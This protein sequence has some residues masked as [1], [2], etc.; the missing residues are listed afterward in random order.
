MSAE[1]PLDGAAALRLLEALGLAGAGPA[2][3]ARR[4][5]RLAEALQDA[6][7]AT[8][9]AAALRPALEHLGIVRDEDGDVDEGEPPLT[10][11]QEESLA[12]QPA[13]RLSLSPVGRVSAESPPRHSRGR[14]SAWARGGGADAAEGEANAPTAIYAKARAASAAMSQSEMGRQLQGALR[15]ATSDDARV[16]LNATMRQLTASVT[17]SFEVGGPL[18]DGF[19]QEDGGVKNQLRRHTAEWL[20]ERLFNESP[21]VKHKS[22]SVMTLLCERGPDTF[23][24]KLRLKE[25]LQAEIEHL[26]HFTIPGEFEPGMDRALQLDQR[27]AQL[28]RHA[29]SKLATLIQTGNS[30]HYGPHL[31]YIAGPPGTGLI[32]GM[33]TVGGSGPGRC[34]VFRSARQGNLV[35][36]KIPLAKILY[37]EDPKEARVPED[38]VTTEKFSSGT[39]VFTPPGQHS[40]ESLVTVAMEEVATGLVS[41]LN[42]LL[43]ETRATKQADQRGSLLGKSLL[44]R[45]RPSV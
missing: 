35:E 6:T 22:I 21:L 4:A 31:V 20:H 34:F 23:L 33:V 15:E 27:P 42:I 9:L 12:E 18:A 7:Q 17:E 2:Q 29:A 36:L 41:V 25:G 44:G 40:S 45:R 11:L 32:Q 16:P 43:E 13:E 28:V 5:A 1:A 19:T 38:L 10:L 37:V 3:R 14:M 26:V 24:P 8:A 39:I 30:Y